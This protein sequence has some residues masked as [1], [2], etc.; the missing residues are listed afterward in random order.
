MKYSAAVIGLGIG[1]R[2]ARTLSNHQDIQNVFVYDIIPISYSN[3]SDCKEIFPCRDI[4]EIY[5]N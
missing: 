1:E 5:H 3:L 4:A 2:H